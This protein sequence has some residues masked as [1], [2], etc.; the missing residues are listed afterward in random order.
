MG[1]SRTLQIVLRLQREL[2]SHMYAGNPKS[3]EISFQNTTF[4]TL[5]ATKMASK[6][7]EV[8]GKGQ[9]QEKGTQKGAQKGPRDPG[10][11]D[12]PREAQEVP[13]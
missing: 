11:K 4:G 1:L 2:D 5:R 13:R 10:A 3:H 8:E 7:S 9:G 6:P 12:T